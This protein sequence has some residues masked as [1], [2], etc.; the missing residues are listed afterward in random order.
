MT[1]RSEHGNGL[2]HFQPPWYTKR[3][4]KLDIDE[5]LKLWIQQPN[6]SKIGLKHVLTSFVDLYSDDAFDGLVAERDLLI[7]A[8][9][10]KLA[11]LADEPASYRPTKRGHKTSNPV[12]DLLLKLQHTV[13]PYRDSMNYVQQVMFLVLKYHKYMFCFENRDD[14]LYRVCQRSRDV[15]LGFPVEVNLKQLV[16]NVGNKQWIDKVEALASSFSSQNN[17]DLIHTRQNLKTAIKPYTGFKKYFQRDSRGRTPLEPRWSHASS[18][19]WHAERNEL[20]EAFSKDATVRTS[21]DKSIKTRDKHNVPEHDYAEQQTVLT[22]PV[23]SYDNECEDGTASRALDELFDTRRLAVKR[24][25]VND[26][27]MANNIARTLGHTSLSYFQLANFIAYLH[28]QSKTETFTFEHS[29]AISYWAL[30]LFTG[31]SDPQLRT[32]WLYLTS[33]YGAQLCLLKEK[34]E[35]YCQYSL[36]SPNRNRE[37]NDSK[38]LKVRLPDWLKQLLQPL[39]QYQLKRTKD[40]IQLFTTEHEENPGRANT[41]FL[42]VRRMLLEAF[43]RS[44]SYQS[45][46]AK[47]LENWLPDVINTQSEF[48]RTEASYISVGSV[49]GRQIPRY[50]LSTSFDRIETLYYAFWSG[51]TDKLNRE[52]KAARIGSVLTAFPS[53]NLGFN[54]EEPDTVGSKRQLDAHQLESLSALLKQQIETGYKQQDWITHHNSYA[55]YTLV[56]L[57]LNAG[58]RAINQPLPSFLHI[59]FNQ[60]RFFIADKAGN[61]AAKARIL[62]LSGSVITQLQAY[63]A[64]LQT[65]HNRLIILN[66]DLSYLSSL[67]DNY[68]L[69][70]LS[71]IR[72]CQSK[73]TDYEQP[74]LFFLNDKFEAVAM[75]HERIKSLLPPDAQEFA[76]NFGRHLFFNRLVEQGLSDEALSV[77]MGHSEHGESTQALYSTMMCDSEPVRKQL[78]ILAES[79][80]AQGWQPLL[81]SG[82]AVKEVKG[83][84]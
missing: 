68:P 11:T 77:L 66:Q 29:A 49:S 67:S 43:N 7:S 30:K 42:K 20:L 32:I 38:H 45:I 17:K 23:L 54:F 34:N 50:Y 55:L 12:Y 84:G 47:Q 5:R 8:A 13:F 18:T 74:F 22:Q 79:Y 10:A 63:K 28:E 44:F 64:H 9:K 61:N 3:S 6:N 78:G 81:D 41:A 73:V 56:Y 53:E 31:M 16:C 2:P 33:S 48:N 39:V 80:R 26:A 27:I 58:L 65:L 70:D 60:K 69:S 21:R 75:T 25:A 59:D 4:V 82:K 76:R 83:N 71:E 35:L 51:V 52:I 1:N 36:S 46:T 14:L 57:Q 15:I 24:K 19:H 62:P 72:T 40:D 37:T